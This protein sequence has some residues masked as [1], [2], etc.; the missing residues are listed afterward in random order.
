MKMNISEKCCKEA[1]GNIMI[2]FKWS[3]S[4]EG[5]DYWNDV[6][7]KLKKYKLEASK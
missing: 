4:K 5:S 1:I 6:V 2:A 7:T 3:K